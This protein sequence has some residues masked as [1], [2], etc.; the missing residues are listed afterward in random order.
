MDQL[1]PMDASFLYF[2]TA[3]AP[4]HIGGLT[5]YDQ[6]TVEGGVL[7]FKRILENYETRL[8]L[9][10]SFR[11]RI[12][13]VPMNLDHPY[14]IE[15][16]NF[17][18]EFHVRHIA[19]P[20][21][22]NWR[23]LCIQVARLHA[24]PLDISRPLWEFT[25][26]EGLDQVEGLPPGSFGIMSKIHHAAI[27]GVSGAEIVA[28]IH[29]IAPD[30]RPAPPEKPWV[31]E[32]DPNVLELLSRTYINNL[33]QPFKLA[34]VVASS[35][36]ALAKVGIGLTAGKLKTAGPVPRTRFNASISPHRVFDG[37]SFSLSDIRAM[38]SAVEGATV[39]DVIVAV[40][41]GAMRKYLEAKDEL[42]KESLIAMAPISVRSDDKKKAAGNLV[43][44]MM[45]SIRTDI[46]DPAERLR[47]VFQATKSSK[48]LTNAIGAKTLSD[49]SQFIP[50]TLSGLAA[51]LY[52]NL[53]IANRIRPFFNTVI[54]NVPGPQI[55]L[56]MTGSRMVTHYGLAPILDGM[57]IIH[58]VF[59]YCGQITVSFTSCR[60]M[61]PDPDF[62]AACIQESFDEM[63]EAMLAEAAASGVE[64]INA[65]PKAKAKAATGPRRKQSTPKVARAKTSAKA[66][67]TAA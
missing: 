41:G 67:G 64:T 27:D 5:I 29:D 17:D 58:P 55:P 49:Y 48:E 60:E 9:A 4:M 1:S 56:Y 3:N 14:W 31:P 10:R 37:R 47:A 13:H 8:H 63:K 25:V 45:L 20:K 59:S 7:G 51:R 19:L 38:K 34:G 2:E 50:S 57:G 33:R 21:P 44:G 43:S 15:D 24:R 6:S 30:A 11:Q 39:N 36:P 52:S 32:R 26:I 35:V 28:A 18:I 54:T 66:A 61:M 23:Q 46:A 62:Y 22:G 12:V 42:P 40:V 53:G 65:K 16:P